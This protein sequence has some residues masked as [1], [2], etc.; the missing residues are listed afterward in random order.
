M[1]LSAFTIIGRILL[2]EEL[3][4]PIVIPKYIEPSHYSHP[5]QVISR[6]STADSSYL[7][8]TSNKMRDIRTELEMRRKRVKSLCQIVGNERSS[9]HSTVSKMI[10]DT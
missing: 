5:E 2:I 6:N 10:V 1:G 8:I 3:P 9:I 4:E 7:I